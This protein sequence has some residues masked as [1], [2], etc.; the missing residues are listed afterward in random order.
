MDAFD[1][2][3]AGQDERVDGRDVVEQAAGSR[4]EREGAEEGQEIV[5]GHRGCGGVGGTR[6][7]VYLGGRQSHP[8]ENERMI[9]HIVEQVERKAAEIE[10]AA[11]QAAQAAE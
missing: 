3:V 7:M 2:R 8:V 10:A 1:Q 9:D 11:T 6:G 5:L 4:V